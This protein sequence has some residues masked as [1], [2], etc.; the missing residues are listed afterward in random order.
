MELLENRGIRTTVNNV[1]IFLD[2][3]TLRIILGPGQYQLFFEFINKV[4]V[5]RTERRTVTSDADLFLMEKL[6]ELEE[7][8][9][10]V[11]YARVIKGMEEIRN[12]GATNIK[13]INI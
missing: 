4:P 10:P 3:E 7:I 6:D 13:G 11:L 5:P 9:I 2:K 12:Q 1:K 8:N